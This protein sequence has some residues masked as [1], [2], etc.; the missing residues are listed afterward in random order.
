MNG[1]KMLAAAGLS[2]FFVCLFFSCNP[3]LGASWYKRSAGEDGGA[4]RSLTVKSIIIYGATLY[5]EPNGE[6]F[7]GTV[8]VTDQD[9]YL[10]PDDIRAV[11]VDN[12]GLPV[13]VTVSIK[14]A[15]GQAAL[16]E[17]E[18]VTVPIRIRDIGDPDI[19]IQKYLFLKQDSS[20]NNGSESANHNPKDPKGNSKFVIKIKTETSTEDPWLYYREGEPDA[21]DNGNFNSDTFD[22]WVLN[23]PSMSGIIASYKFKEGVWSGSSPEVCNNAPPEIGEGLKGIWDVKVYRYKSRAERWS[24]SYVP[25][26]DPK[27]ERFHFFKFTAQSNG[28]LV[29][30]SMFCVDRY[31]KFLFYYSEPAVIK[32][33]LN[34]WV[35]SNWTDYAAPTQ[36]KHNKF[37]EPFYM[38]DPVGFVKEDGTVVLYEWIIKN[39]NDANYGAKQNPSYTQP[40]GRKSN[41]AGFSPY[42]GSVKVTK[43]TVIKD[44]NA[45]YTAVKPVILEQPQ[46]KYAKPDSPKLIFKVETAPVPEGETLSYQ[47]YKADMRTGDGEEIAGATEAS[48]EVADMSAEMLCYFYCVVTNTNEDNHRSEQTESERAKCHITAGEIL[49]DALAPEITVQPKQDYTV[50]IK[51][52]AAPITLRVQAVSKDG[53]TL[54]YQWYK[55][56]SP[57]GEGIT[58][59][60]DEAQTDTYTFTPDTSAASTVYY[61]CMVTN[62]NTAVNGQQSAVKKSRYTAVEV[63]ESYKIE[64]SVAGEDGGALTALHNGK[65][66]DSGVYIKKGE[67]IQFIAT[68]QT[69]LRY[70]VKE[71][72]GVSLDDSNPKS[73]FAQLTVEDKD[74][75]VSVAFEQKMYLTVRPGISN[76]DLRSWSTADGDRFSPKYAGG[77]HL[78]HKCAVRV[79]GGG[80]VAKSW[81]YMF[82]VKEDSGKWIKVQEKDF[83]KVGTDTFA[84]SGWLNAEFTSFSDLK[85]ALTDYLLK[86]NRHDYWWA[87][88]VSWGKE[89]PLQAIDNN[90]VFPL[91]Y[92]E[93]AG[94]WTVDKSH[95]QVKQSNE[96]PLP[97]EFVGTK[98]KL[99]RRISYKGVTITYDENFTLRDGEEKDFVITYKVDN[100]NAT[101]SKGTVKMI[102]RIGWK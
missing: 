7:I 37:P 40:A 85:I 19:E 35:P 17:G 76:E 51:S 74:E 56:D 21:S 16:K 59:T 88:Y 9:L 75:S 79:N 15:G 5:P 22:R 70:K 98:P 28:G 61:Y 100:E 94:Q 6:D 89:Y 38:S 13:D 41:K 53:G 26:F 62:T 78:S 80:N 77:V 92:N 34:N 50:R 64:F 49:V 45:R 65:P 96:I 24:G 84:Q 90:S 42:R 31:S 68:P 101:K 73:T 83:I 30:S 97:A 12:K 33:I 3:A 67:R 86:A 58:E 71:W 2:I 18:I 36:G 87:E 91:V 8:N 54:S 81:D 46:D 95:V 47:W 102:Y 48:Y 1:K 10:Y 20:M 66:I 55:A 72:A 52:Q 27:D 23:M 29:D 93:T 57:I 63:E 82:P 69:K 60:G 25:E 39:I 44:K 4:K 11:V 99:N 43:K 32:N 14:G